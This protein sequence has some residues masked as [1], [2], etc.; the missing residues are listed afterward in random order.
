ML[1]FSRQSKTCILMLLLLKGGKDDYHIKRDLLIFFNIQCVRARIVRR[2]VFK[3]H[4]Y[5]VWYPLFVP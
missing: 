2:H 5:Y 4:E 3:S 1:F